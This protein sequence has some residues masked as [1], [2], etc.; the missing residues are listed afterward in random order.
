ML[1]GNAGPWA[2]RSESGPDHT[3]VGH[4]RTL[5]TAKDNQEWRCTKEV[6]LDVKV[7]VSTQDCCELRQS[8]FAGIRPLTDG[9]HAKAAPLQEDTIVVQVERN[10]S[11]ENQSTNNRLGRR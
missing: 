8:D 6:T 9:L 10:R 5:V 11:D 1:G 4:G 7:K 3:G 2:R